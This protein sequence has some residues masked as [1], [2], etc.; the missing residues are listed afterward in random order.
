MQILEDPIATPEN[1]IEEREIPSDRALVPPLV[2]RLIERLTNEG[3]VDD[4]QRM[5]AEL[6]LDEAITNAV[7]HGNKSDFSK[8][9]KV[10]LFRGEDHWGVVVQDQGDGFNIED[11]VQ[12]SPSDALWQ[13]SGRGLPLMEVYMDEV[14]FYDGGRTLYLRRN[15]V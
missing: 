13:E 9:V 14:V 11:I 6:C 8:M 2:V 15:T 10:S 1:V 12:N 5:K 4:S 7:L 3:L